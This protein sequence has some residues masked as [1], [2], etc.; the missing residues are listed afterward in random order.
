MRFCSPAPA[1]AP[2]SFFSGLCRWQ[3][4]GPQA[5]RRRRAH[6]QS[7]CRRLRRRACGPPRSRHKLHFRRLLFQQALRQAVHFG[8][9]RCLDVVLFQLIVPPVRL[10]NG[11]LRLPQQCRG[12]LLQKADAYPPGFYGA[13]IIGKTLSV[14]G[15]CPA[16]VLQADNSLAQRRNCFMK[17][18]SALVCHR[19]EQPQ[20]LA[21]RFAQVRQLPG[22]QPL[23]IVLDFFPV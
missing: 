1:G 11:Q 20:R 10:G 18:N 9:I 23:H 19:G 4:W 7:P 16:G 14:D 8:K 6:G 13:A 15:P 21:A 3:A 5:A 22:S 17:Q 2:G 12:C